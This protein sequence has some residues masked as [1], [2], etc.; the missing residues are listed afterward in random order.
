MVKIYNLVKFKERRREL[1]KKATS[2][3]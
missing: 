1:R 2:E 3:R